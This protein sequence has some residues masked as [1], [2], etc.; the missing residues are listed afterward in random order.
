MMRKLVIGAVAVAA[1]AAGLVS[2]RAVGTTPAVLAERPAGCGTLP[3][4][5][6]S[7]APGLATGRGLWAV[8]GGRLVSVGAG[9]SVQPVS[10]AGESTIRHVAASEGIGTAYVVDRAGGDVLVA[11]TPERTIRLLRRS[12]ISH[13]AWSPAG[14]L[15]WATG[16]SIAVR[17]GGTGRIVQLRSPVSGGRVFS[18]VYLTARTLVAAVSSPPSHRVPEGERLGNLWA[19]RIDRPRWRRLTDFR[20]GADRWVTVRT[21][22][23]RD[24]GIDFVR[25]VG[26]GSVARMP[27]FELWRLEHGAARRVA[28][29]GEERYLAGLVGGRLVW[30]VPE[31]RRGRYTLAVED[32]G[33][34]RTIGCGEVTV[35]PLD[36]VD[37]DRRGGRGIHVPARGDWPELEAASDG[38]AEE[39]AVIVGDFAAPAEAEAVATTIRA[40]FPGSRVDVV[41]STEA[42]LAIRPG[43]FGALLHLPL[44]A[45]PTAA[46]ADF[47]R[48]L[49]EYAPNSWIVTP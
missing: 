36:A 28:T 41:D 34:L 38:H 20:A 27:R 39:I 4:F 13:P 37:P 2:G 19:T 17:D 32:R 42:P 15:A 16:S 21:P 14:D 26:R 40:A 48:L 9:R 12:E 46:L 24:H 5:A 44:D 47:R 30:N 3:A 49:P 11:V 10:R 22:V 33:G 31:P 6:R 45:D 35:D 43:V 29:L 1:T 7:T 23:V 25:V 8:A 18:P